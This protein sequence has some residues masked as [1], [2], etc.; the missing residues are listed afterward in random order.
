M[1]L[2][3]DLP[4]RFTFRI[5]ANENERFHDDA[6]VDQIG[7][8]IHV[9]NVGMATIVEAEVVNGGRAA[10]ITMEKVKTSG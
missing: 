8:T 5:P 6:L 10:L 7:R 1:T 4:D 2:L 3:K 9:E